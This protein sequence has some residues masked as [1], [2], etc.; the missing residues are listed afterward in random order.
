MTVCKLLKN[1]GASRDRTDDLIVA[2]DALSQLSYSPILPDALK[3]QAD[4]IS[5]LAIS[6]STTRPHKPYRGATNHH[7]SGLTALPRKSEVLVKST[8]SGQSAV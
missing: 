1:G 7:L 8:N 3:R 5:P 2:N 4:F 6:T